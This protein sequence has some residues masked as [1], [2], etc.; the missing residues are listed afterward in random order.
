MESHLE[1]PEKGISLYSVHAFPLALVSVKLWWSQVVSPGGCW[2]SEHKEE[3]TGDG[4]GTR[5]QDA[6]VL[7][8][9]HV[10]SI[11]LAKFLDLCLLSIK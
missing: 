7:A 6:C 9:S 2:A 3:Y 8:H 10:S 1:V 11:N 4:A 5:S